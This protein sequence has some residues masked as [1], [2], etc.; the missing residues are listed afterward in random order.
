MFPLA[1]DVR[2]CRS[3]VVRPCPH[4]CNVRQRT[5]HIPLTRFHCPFVLFSSV[6]ST[7]YDIRPNYLMRTG[8]ARNASM[9]IPRPSLSPPSHPPY[10]LTRCYQPEASALAEHRHLHNDMWDPAAEKK[11]DSWSPFLSMFHTLYCMRAHTV[12]A[13]ATLSIYFMETRDTLISGFFFYF[14]P[15]TFLHD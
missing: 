5:I 15:L 12:N 2:W 13:K 7:D 14:L 4:R 1:S 10:T 3:G 9:L 6:Y 11:F 8:L